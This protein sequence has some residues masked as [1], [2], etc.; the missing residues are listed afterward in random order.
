MGYNVYVKVLDASDFGVPQARKRVY[1]VGIDNNIGKINFDNLPT[2]H[3]TFS[4]VREYGLPV[5]HSAF[6]KKLLA[7]YT[8]NQLEGKNIKDKR[9]GE[10]N[11]HSWDISLKGKVTKQEKD[12]LNLLLKERRKKKWAE[13]IGID[14]MDGMPLTQEQIASF[15]KEKNLTSMLVS[16]TE[17]G[18]LVYEYP[19]KKIV[20]SRNGNTASRREPD[21]TK[22]KG[23]NIV[24][25][26]LSFEFSQ[27]LD[28]NS[29]APTMVAM[30]MER[31][32]VVEENG[33]R[34][35][36]I[37]E[38]LR[39]FGYEDYDLSYL[40]NKKRGRTIAFDLL[41]NSVC[42]PVIQVLAERLISAINKKQK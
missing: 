34:H 14:W 2:S 26:K 37:D 22:P 23:Y 16:L 36:T 5:E 17:K 38:G 10:H 24:T 41:G 28:S 31:I 20:I 8:P 13:L 30:D 39:L 12:F 40:K 3:T 27:F 15:Y 11:I 9:G 29:I 35:L 32:G 19:K 18:Y 4:N 21:T 33:V 1:I 7:A 25:G 6:T 42:V